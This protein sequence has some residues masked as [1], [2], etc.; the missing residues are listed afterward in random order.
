MELRFSEIISGNESIAKSVGPLFKEA[1]NTSTGEEFKKVHAAALTGYYIEE[2]YHM[3]RFAQANASSVE[4]QKPV[5]QSLQTLIN[6]KERV[7]HLIG[8]FDHIQLKSEGIGAYQDLLAMQTEYLALDSQVL[9]EQDP[10]LI[11]QN[12]HVQEI[13]ELVV[14]VRKRIIE[15]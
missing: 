3:A 4:M 7:N 12:S 1:D 11:L 2:L 14:S 9:Q 10:L 15:S 8:Y 13:I 5:L 6:Q